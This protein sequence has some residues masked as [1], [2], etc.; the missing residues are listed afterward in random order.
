MRK[1][2]AGWKKYPWIQFIWHHETKKREENVHE[3]VC[4]CVCVLGETAHLHESSH[5]VKF[6]CAGL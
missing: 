1:F 6:F 2:T 5:N 3:P 4:V